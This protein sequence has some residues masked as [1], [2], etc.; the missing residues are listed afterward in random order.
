MEPKQS[1]CEPS[2]QHNE[3]QVMVK[4]MDIQG[5]KHTHTAIIHTKKQTSKHSAQTH[6]M[7][8][9]MLIAQILYCNS[10]LQDFDWQ[11]PNSNAFQI[12]TNIY[13]NSAAQGHKQHQSKTF[14]G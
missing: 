2:T 3:R 5:E 10:K 13:K 4:V 6:T 9:P 7:P 14:I 8:E 11:P 1:Q 12:C